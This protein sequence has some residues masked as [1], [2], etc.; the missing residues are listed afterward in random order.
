MIVLSNNYPEDLLVV[1]W[2]HLSPRGSHGGHL[3]FFG[4]EKQ[5]GHQPSYGLSDKKIYEI[6]KFTLMII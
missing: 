2:G 3:E 4:F 1:F 5:D 6:K